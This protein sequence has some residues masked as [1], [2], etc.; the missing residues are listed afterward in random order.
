MLRDEFVEFLST[1]FRI[2]HSDDFA[3]VANAPENGATLLIQHPADR[4]G[5]CWN[6][7]TRS[8]KLDGFRFALFHN[9][10]NFITHCLPPFTRAAIAS[11]SFSFGKYLSASSR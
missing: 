1:T 7:R 2:V 10:G 4:P 3:V 8:P 6:V 11:V 5:Q 9:P